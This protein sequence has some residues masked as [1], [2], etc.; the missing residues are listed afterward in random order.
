MHAHQWH[1]LPRTAW[2]PLVPCCFGSFPQRPTN[3]ARVQSNKVPTY[4]LLIGRP[5]IL[6]LAESTNSGSHFPIPF[7][8]CFTPSSTKYNQKSY[9]SK[10]RLARATKSSISFFAR[11]EGAL[12]PSATHEGGFSIF[13][14]SKKVLRAHERV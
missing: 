2:M 13:S 5:R 14:D 3:P 9:V 7:N 4:L 1:A 11:L 8:E 6:P 12:W 10:L